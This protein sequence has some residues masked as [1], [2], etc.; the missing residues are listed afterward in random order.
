[1][2]YTNSLMVSARVGGIATE[3]GRA[4]ALVERL[5]MQIMREPKSRERFPIG[6]HRLKRYIRNTLN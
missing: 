2:A 3:K 4:Q 6:A 5:V 1:M